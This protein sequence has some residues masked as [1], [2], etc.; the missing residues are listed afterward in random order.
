MQQHLPFLSIVILL[1]FWPAEVKF[2]AAGFLPCIFTQLLPECWVCSGNERRTNNAYS[3]IRPDLSDIIPYYVTPPFLFFTL[4]PDGFL[5]GV[6]VWSWSFPLTDVIDPFLNICCTDGC[7]LWFLCTWW[8]SCSRYRLFC[9][10]SSSQL[11]ISSVSEHC[12]LCEA[13]WV[14]L[15]LMPCCPH[16]SRLIAA[17]LRLSADSQ[18]LCAA[19]GSPGSSF[20]SRSRSHRDVV[21]NTKSE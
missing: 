5:R 17:L 13:G 19:G 10:T 21:R 16:H 2:R 9:F 4:N 7:C 3:L 12:V 11:A 6:S 18:Q 14:L 20:S 8:W 15:M 1:E